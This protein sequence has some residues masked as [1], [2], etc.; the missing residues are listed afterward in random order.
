MTILTKTVVDFQWNDDINEDSDAYKEIRELWKYYHFGNDN[1]YYEWINDID[2]P[3]WPAIAAYLKT[4]P[5]DHP[6]LLH[7]WW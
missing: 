1:Y 5:Q 6:F 2:E 4:L 3:A 7:W